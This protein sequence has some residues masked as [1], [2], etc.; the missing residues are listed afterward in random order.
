MTA[1]DG[2]WSPAGRNPWTWKADIDPG[3]IKATYDKGILNVR[4]PM[5]EAVKSEAARVPIEK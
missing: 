3:K 4:V 2:L 5:P 1:E